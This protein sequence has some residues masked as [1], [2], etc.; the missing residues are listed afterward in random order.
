MTTLNA[1]A[2]LAQFKA[3]SYARGQSAAMTIDA[4]DDTVA[5][6]LL[7]AASRLIER[8]TARFFYPRV[9]TH[10]FDVPTGEELDPRQLR[11]D[12]D[13]LE[14]ITLT[15]GDDVAIPSTE[16]SLIDRNHT[17]YYAI[18]LKDNST[19][20]WASDGA[21]D[22]H[23]VIEVLGIW[24]YHDRY[25][26]AW[27]SGGN[28]NEALD[29]SEIGID[30]VT[31]TNFAIG[32]IIKIENELSYLSNVVTNTL[33]G[34]RGEN[35]STAAT[36]DTSKT[37]YIWQFMEDIRE[38][39]LLIAHNAYL[40]RTGES[41]SQAATVTAAGVVLT[42]EAIPA[43]VMHVLDGLKRVLA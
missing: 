30:V 14:I 20:V 8:K 19:Y 2:T 31:G 28:T 3:Y 1:Y 33:T 27:L 4:T 42:P 12:G 11:M 15:N 25:A 5:E 43:R 34:T 29:A 37:A 22:T 6:D 35:G 18:R 26:N 16:Y 36:H 40:N 7:K 13:L 10:Y 23:G 21:G 17:P 32:N 38:A 39:C 24:G 9:E 41:G